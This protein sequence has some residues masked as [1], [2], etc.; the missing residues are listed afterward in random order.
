MLLLNPR[1]WHQYLS[2]K[3]ATLMGNEEIF[4]VTGNG[5]DLELT[6]CV[7][8]ALLLVHTKVTAPVDRSRHTSVFPQHL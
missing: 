6:A 2:F 1:E 7:A 8:L 3:L 5:P 4:A